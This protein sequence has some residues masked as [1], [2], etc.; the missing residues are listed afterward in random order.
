MALPP[1]FKIS[2]P[3]CEATGCAVT[4]AAWSNSVTVWVASAPCRQEMK[5]KTKPIT[6]SSLFIPT[7]LLSFLVVCMTFGISEILFVQ[8]FLQGGGEVNACLIGQANEDKRYI[9][10]LL[11]A[12][13]LLIRF[14][15]GLLPVLTCHDACDFA[16]FLH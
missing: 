9:R 8:I 13:H 7:E 11:S 4:T 5:V 1:C 10:H 15:E 6:Q 16:H 14:L 3:T 2:T 12:V